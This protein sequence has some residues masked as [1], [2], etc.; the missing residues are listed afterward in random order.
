[1]RIESDRAEILSGVRHGETLGSPVSLLIRNRDWENWTT[2]MS[3]APVDARRREE[4]D[5]CAACYLPRPGHADLVGVL[6]YDR[7]RRAR[8]PGARER[9]RDRRAGRRRGA[10]PSG[11]WRSWGSAIG[12]H[13]TVARRGGGRAVRRRSRRTLNAASDASP[14]RC[15]D[16][17]RGGRD[18]RP[19]ST[20]RSGTA[21]PWA[22]SSRWWRAALPPGLGSHVS[23]DRKLDGRLAGA[24][25]SIQAIKGVE[26]GLGFAAAAPSRLAACTTRSLREPAARRRLRARGQ[27]RRGAGGR[28]HHRPAAGGARRR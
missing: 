7:R 1:M 18:D 28:D 26:I 3:A 5:D 20:R 22:G 15:L 17:E 12:S 6:K 8:H 13:V 10:W 23:W 14:V 16:A 24:L 2:A 21:T 25:M 4:E 19:R 27:Q 9:P 11:S